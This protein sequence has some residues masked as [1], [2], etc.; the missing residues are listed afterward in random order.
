ME[1][2]F[3]VAE[4]TKLSVGQALEKLS[5]PD[6]PK[7]KMARLDEKI[8]T[9]DQETQRLRAMRHRI[10]RGQRAGP[11]ER[12]TQETNVR[13]VTKLKILGITIGIVIVIPILVWM[14]GLLSP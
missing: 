13:R 1:E 6:A 5:G 8:D 3:A 14:W 10:E 2:D 7:A 4:I 11:T 9:L 12:L